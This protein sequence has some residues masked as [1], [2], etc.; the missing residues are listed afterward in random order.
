[1]KDKVTKRAAYYARVSTL[2]Q[3]EGDTIASQIT[4][5][6][7]AINASGDVIDERHKFQDNGIS[8]ALDSTATLDN[9]ITKAYDG[10]FDRLYI[11]HP[12][13]LARNL[14]RQLSLSA[15][16]K[17]MGIELVFTKFTHDETPESKLFLQ[18]LGAIS[19]FERSLIIR[20]LTEGKI[21]KVSSGI[22]FGNIPP[23]GYDYIRKTPEEAGRLVINDTEAAVVK[24]IFS[25]WNEGLSLSDM[26]RELENRGIKTRKGKTFWTT[27]FIRNL[28]KNETYIGTTHWGKT[29][30]RMERDRDDW[31][32]IKVP[33]IVS[34]Q[35]F[36]EVNDDFNARVRRFSSI[37]GKKPVANEYF[38]RGLI[39]CGD[40]DCT[41]HTQKGGGYLK[42]K[43]RAR[44]YVCRAKKDSWNKR[45]VATGTKYLEQLS[46]D[47]KGLVRAE[48]IEE[49]VWDTCKELMKN[50][51]S[52][53]HLVNQK[54][55]DARTGNQMHVRRLNDN[56]SKTQI[57]QNR[58]Q[59]LI[60]LAT[61]EIISTEDF[62]NTIGQLNLQKRQLEE[63]RREIDKRFNN[64]LEEITEE[65]VAADAREILGVM[66]NL[67]IQQKRRLIRKLVSKVIVS[68]KEITM[69]M[70]VILGGNSK[71]ITDKEDTLKEVLLNDV[72]CQ[73][74]DSKEYLFDV[75]F[76]YSMAKGH[77]LIHETNLKSLIKDRYF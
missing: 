40:C 7:T 76:V 70:K 31:Y 67:T 62:A 47:C 15:T 21:K 74:H 20:R 32:P 52:I 17:K 10:E 16:F 25:S 26:C 69:N 73:R 19:E 30:N 8:G 3:K 50:P 29:L 66:N 77:L 68:S 37:Y 61:K 36:K 63:E 64:P 24:L 51:R 39:T 75:N 46:P 49:L 34:K 71:T 11:T 18:M 23:Y 1:M 22:V 65:Q 13:R 27:T 43:D 72:L 41:R 59:K 48:R 57:L 42:D 58:R 60:D 54:I 53:T 56:N 33:A 2:T 35:V 5:L 4:E 45:R 55:K 14:Q 9:L 38:L 44:Y 6:E 28:L 12:D